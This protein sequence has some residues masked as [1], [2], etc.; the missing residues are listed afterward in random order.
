MIWKTKK[1]ND[2]KSKSLSQKRRYVNKLFR[3]WENLFKND[4]RYFQEVRGLND[5]NPRR[6][7]EGGEC[8]DQKFEIIDFINGSDYDY[9]EFCNFPLIYSD[10]VYK[11]LNE[12]YGKCIFLC[13][14]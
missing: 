13:V 9:A 2:I 7:K 10:V 3:N 8:Y 5:W 11:T 4:L 14:T 6:L 12:V 1:S